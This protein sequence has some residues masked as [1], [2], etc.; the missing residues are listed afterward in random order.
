VSTGPNALA[1][2]TGL[3]P[4]PRM[5]KNGIMLDIAG[6]AAIWLVVWAYFH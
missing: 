6:A 3:V 4:L 2:G 5:M 1:Y